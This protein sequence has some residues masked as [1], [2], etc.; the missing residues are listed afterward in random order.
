MYSKIGIHFFIVVLFFCLAITEAQTEQRHSFWFLL[1]Q[2]AAKVDDCVDHRSLMCRHHSTSMMEGALKQLEVI[3][4]YAKELPSSEQ[5]KALQQIRQLK[6]RITIIQK[7]VEQ[8]GHQFNQGTGS[9]S[10]ILT[11]AATGNPI[12]NIGVEIFDTTGQRVDYTYTNSLGQYQI[13]NLMPG[14]FF[15]VTFSWVWNGPYLD[16][17]YDNLPCIWGNCDPISGSPII[18]TDG[19]VTP[20]IDFALDEGGVITGQVTQAEDGAALRAWVEAYSFSGDDMAFGSTDHSGRYRI[21]GL[22]RG[23]YFLVATSQDRM[24]KLYDNKLQWPFDSYGWW[25]DLTSKGT[26]VDVTAGRTTKDINFSLA[27]GGTITGSVRSAGTRQPIHARVIISGSSFTFRT[28]SDDQ[29]KFTATSFP[30]GTY[31]ASAEG[32][33]SVAGGTVP[34]IHDNHT[35]LYCSTKAGTPIQVLAGQTTTRVTFSLEQGG[36]LDVGGYTYYNGAIAFDI[37]GNEIGDFSCADPCC[38]CWLE[39]LPEADYFV[40]SA[41]G[42]VLNLLYP[43]IP[44]AFN[45]CD[46]T[47]G[48]PVHVAPGTSNDVDFNFTRGGWITGI[49]TDG[50]NPLWSSIS[51]FD[52]NGNWVTWGSC[53]E[54][55]G[56]Y[57]TFLG[58]PTG[59]YFVKAG[60]I[61][62][63]S[64]LYDN[65]P[66]TAC[67]PKEGDQVAVEVNVETPGINFTLQPGGGIAGT[68]IDKKTGISLSGVELLIYDANGIYISSARTDVSGNY[69][70]QPNLSD[71][72]Y[73][74]RTFNSPQYYIDQLFS[75]IP[76]PAGVCD[77][78]AGSP[79]A[80][81]AGSIHTGVDFALAPGGRIQGSIT[82][83]DGAPLQN[84]TVDVY[85]SQGI[86]LTSG[87]SDNE[88]QYEV[89]GLS[90]GTYYA[91]ASEADG[92]QESELYGDVPC[93]GGI[94][95]PT[96]GT[97]ISVVAGSTQSGISI[98]LERASY[99]FCDSFEDNILNTNWVLGRPAWAELE[100]VL[101]GTPQ[102]GK[103]TITALAGDFA[104][105]DV[106]SVETT[107]TTIGV[108]GRMTLLGWYADGSNNVRL[109]LRE[110]TGKWTLEQLSGGHLVAS[111]TAHKEVKRNV[112]YRVK[113]A[114]DGTRFSVFVDD[115]SLPLMTLIPRAPVTSGTVG[116]EVKRGSA[117]FGY[118]K[119]E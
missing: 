17:L 84:I 79:I 35:C 99:L 11:D 72:N 111:V 110:G 102:R 107:M 27:I 52:L 26:P 5:M 91:K 3:K 65:I 15:A 49:V 13:S 71:G 62:Y 42:Y 112:T 14:T 54:D 32:D 1:H 34:E 41:R 115:S 53:C 94:C 30:T 10:G 51:V 118:I 9:I 38:G 77:P 48:T 101:Y 2:V 93:P 18:V 4:D 40:E 7:S 97:P 119:V 56:S 108:P 64:E 95:D 39:G 59:K 22:P 88:G 106:C 87:T 12:E 45:E 67:D 89:K 86:H 113:L 68:V 114:F 85:N 73:Y 69:A 75:N 96:K 98:E 92:C 29:G 81:T 47:Q 50:T 6:Q 83:A 16:K 24:S 44:C 76:C 82:G 90:T 63:V 37:R 103:G 117:R 60:S 74:V 28:W 80:V 78:T 43:N 55:D 70:F 21:I 105:C 20:G 104:G 116:F 25:D 33:S 66:C 19:N 61:G 31:F 109:T 57:A 100:G 23:V 36:E 58:L 8:S 46:P